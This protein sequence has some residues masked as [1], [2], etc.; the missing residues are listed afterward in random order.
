VC[1]LVALLNAACWSFIT[2]PFQV[3]DEQDHFAYVQQ[4]AE[5]GHLPSKSPPSQS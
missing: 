4:L 1:A 5:T 2:P 3:P